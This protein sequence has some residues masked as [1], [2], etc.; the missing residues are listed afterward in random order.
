MWDFVL[1][2]VR[3]HR[4]LLT[5]AVLAV[6]LTT[7]VLAMLSAFSGAIGDASLRHM[8]RTRD[9]T[10]T[11]LVVKADV[12]ASGRDAAASAVRK[13]TD[14]AFDG[15]PVRWQSLTSSGAYAL[16][17]PDRDRPD[18]TRFAVLDRSEV[19]LTDGR[20]PRARAG[21]VVEAA[22]P[23]AAAQQLKLT[24]GDRLVLTDR[25]A[26]RKLTVELTGVYRP[27]RPQSPYWALDELGGHGVQ[28][29]SFTTYGPLMADPSLLS[30]GR[31][32]AGE[33]AWLAAADFSAVTTGRI[34][35]LR[36]AARA[37]TRQLEHDPALAGSVT[38]TGSLPDVL[39]RAERALL[40]SRSTLLI[41]ALQLVLLAGYALLLVAR[42]L[43]AERAGETWTLRARGGSRGRIA[44]LAAR[45]ALLLALP[46]AVCAPLLAGPLTRL[47]AAQGALSRIGLKLDVGVSAASVW[48]VGIGVAVG[49]ALAVTLPALTSQG[50]GGG[51][52]RALPAPLRA[53][54]DVG[55]LVVAAVAYWQLDQQ[56]SGTGALSSDSKGSLGIDP[57]LVVAPALAL[58]AGTV[59]TLRLLPP[60]ARLAERGAARGKGLSMALAGWQFSRRPM[61][62]AGPVLLLVLASAMGMLA[63]GQGASWDRSQRDQA[64]F[65][66]GA[67]VRVQGTEPGM[68]QA[69]AYPAVPGVKDAA[70]ARRIEV[71]LQSGRTSTALALDTARVHDGML[72][73]GDLSGSTPEKVLGAVRPARAGDP[74]V[75]VPKDARGLSFALRAVNVR[76]QKGAPPN[77]TTSVAATVVDRFGLPYR[78]ALGALPVDG[79]EHR[80]DAEL[81]RAAHPLRLMGLEFVTERHIGSDASQKVTLGSVR[82]RSAAGADRPLDLSV[83]KWRT[84]LPDPE[85]TT[86]GDGSAAGSGAPATAP[87]VERAGS[88][89]TFT[90]NTGF[91]PAGDA[92]FFVTAPSTT[93]RLTVRQRV[94][95]TV[96]AV[97]TDR[98]LASA[99]L[100]KGD[101]MDLPVP[102]GTVRIRIAGSVRALPTTGAADPERDGGAVLLDLHAANR[103]LTEVGYP[104][105]DPD[106]W[107]LATK[108]GGDARAAAAARDLPGIDASQVTS[109]AELVDALRDD[110]LGAGP[111]S[112]LSAAALV[113]AALAAVGF[114]VNT[115]GSL[116]ERGDEF[117]VLTA[118]GASRRRLTRLVAAE[119]GV[120]VAI[121]LLVGAALGAFLT[122]AVVPL[123]VLTG[124][125][126]RPVPEV[127]IQLPPSQVALLLGGVALTPVLII[128][129]LAL[130][131]PPQLASVLRTQGGE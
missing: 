69:A 65:R 20:L 9:A 91:V 95:L 46:A 96:P 75:P 49:C 102:T 39:T 82:A 111:Q 112:A 78:L 17:G 8:L 127:A 120:L 26:G 3:A 51:R 81:G 106:E 83:T 126:T 44:S 116:R 37:G 119:Q 63:V 2:R 123:I 16:P 124:D 129:A 84:Q 59:L 99:D 107:W 77:E 71:P 10:T 4:L 68:A 29:V 90:Y 80:L 73:R 98:F 57:L 60:V 53:G 117:A 56:T 87:R 48:L 125:A 22:L 41:V 109:R 89:L 62:G 93:V 104:A 121:G 66:A 118:L 11:A 130:R 52:A 32:G 92:G 105:L 38:V 74:G 27:A 45:E 24:P 30:G 23:Q 101:T 61:R 115:V 94:A 100:K 114:A 110:P 14:R 31:V 33:S 6:L 86:S 19:K 72:M 58:L 47:V 34:D 35:A 43:S 113:A 28:K 85:G 12:L 108:P 7:S 131:R 42:L 25:L 54:A 79:R 88:G 5:A 18:L 55:L 21:K 50:P 76:G 128:A 1:L 122:R 13:G 40:V 67:S 36:D 15:L 70:P 97:A 103:A 64:D